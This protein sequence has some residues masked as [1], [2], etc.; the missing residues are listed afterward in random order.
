MKLKHSD[1]NL[2]NKKISLDGGNSIHS[3]II[4][5]Q[6]EKSFVLKTDSLNGSPLFY[7]LNII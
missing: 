6:I 4:T 1:D 5:E 2:I 7:L 3:S